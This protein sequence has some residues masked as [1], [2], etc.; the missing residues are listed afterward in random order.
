MEK[1]KFL[2]VAD[3]EGAAGDI[4]N[5]LREW[6]YDAAPAVLSGS[7]ALQAL[8][9]FDADLV[10]M[11]IKDADDLE[12]ASQIRKISGLPV[13]FLADREDPALK[14]RARE[15]GCG[16]I[17]APL[18][19]AALRINI[20]TSL[21]GHRSEQNP[22]DSGKPLQKLELRVRERTAELLKINKE[23]RKE[24]S[25]RKRIEKQLLLSKAYAEEANASQ[26]RFLQ[27]MSHELRTPLGHIIGFAKILKDECGDSLSEIHAEFLDDI[28]ESAQCLLDRINLILEFTG[29]MYGK[30]S[31]SIAEL[32]L[33]AI[34]QD[35]VRMVESLAGERGIEITADLARAGSIFADK[36]MVKQ[37]FHNLLFNAYK[38]NAPDGRIDLAANR[39]ENEVTIMVADTGI[40][41]DPQD[42]KKVFTEF[43]QID[44]AANREFEG[45][46][47]GLALTKKMVELHG[48]RIWFESQKGKGSTFYV[49]FPVKSSAAASTG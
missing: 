15:S 11:G 33:E 18:D 3:P 47:L 43:S 45:I 16:Y 26:A 1:I 10:L 20:E 23:L 12:T 24:I 48:G 36:R 5:T 25:E 28:S 14:R 21:C 30:V 4:R 32:D 13:I 8:K 2:V 7:E 46:G 44:N 19:H 41:I 27:T 34:L 22:Q 39:T 31:S 17:A 49:S 35:S 42:K 29:F 40:G 37:I 6:G 38:F 9:R